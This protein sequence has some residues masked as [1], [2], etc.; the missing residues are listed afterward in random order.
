VM[1]P[2]MSEM[3]IESVTSQTNMRAVQAAAP[4]AVSENVMLFAPSFKSSAF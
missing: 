1:V 2:S 4:D 3:T